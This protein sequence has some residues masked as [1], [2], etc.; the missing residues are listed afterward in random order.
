M[1]LPE[2]LPGDPSP[3]GYRLVLFD[4]DGVLVDSR[5]GMS[6]AWATVQR[7]LAVTVPFEDYFREIGRPFGEI[8]DRLGLGA[9]LAAI[10]R[11]YWRVAAAEIGRV[12]PYPEVIRALRRVASAGR[13]VGVV[14]SK[15]RASA[16]QTLKQFDIPFATLKTPDDGRGKPAPDL[17]VS[18]VRELGVEI[19]ETI[20]IGDMQVDH[21][22]ARNAGM[23]FLHA[24]WGYGERP[25]GA[26]QLHRARDIAGLR[27]PRP[28]TRAL[29][30]NTVDGSGISAPASLV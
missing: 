2:L 29:R 13:L 11:V 23:R 22:A 24:A 27:G 26:K 14:T 21:E 30:A 18:A 6:I 5:E 16:V 7:E 3:L 25:E 1:R 19:W 10:E 12:R 9:Q 20:Y 15:K 17:L 28:R 4:L 8:I